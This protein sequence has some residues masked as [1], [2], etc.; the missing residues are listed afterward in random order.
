M[1]PGDRRFSAVHRG[2]TYLFRGPDEQQRFISDPDRYAT[3]RFGPIMERVVNAMSAGKGGGG[4]DLAGGKVVDMPNEYE[5]WLEAQRSD[6][7]S[8]HRV[9]L[10][11][12]SVKAP[13]LAISIA[14][15]GLKIV[16]V[17]ESW[18]SD[19]WN[20]VTLTDLQ[21]ALAA[22][23]GKFSIA[24]LQPTVRPFGIPLAELVKAPSGLRYVVTRARGETFVFQTRKGDLGLMQ[25]VGFT[26]DPRGIRLRYKLVQRPT[27][28]AAEFK[29]FLGPWKVARIQKGDAAGSSWRGD[30][31]GEI[32]FDHLSRVVFD[33]HYCRFQEMEE[34]ID[35]T[36]EW[37]F[38]PT[39]VP[40]TIGL[41]AQSSPAGPGVLAALGVY[42]LQ[43]DQ[44]K[45]CLAK[46]SP[47]LQSEQ[48]PS[49][50]TIRP[51]SG[52][53]LLTLERYQPSE[54][55]KAFQGRWNVVSQSDSGKAVP[56]KE[57]EQRYFEAFDV[58]AYLR[59]G[60]NNK[61]FPRD[62]A[63]GLF[64][65]DP[66]T[67]PK[68]IT[69]SGFEPDSTGGFKTDE[70]NNYKKQRLVG[71]YKFDGD[72]LTIA[73][74]TN[75]PRPE[76]FESTPGSGVTLLVLERPRQESV[77]NAD[78]VGTQRQPS[79]KGPE[80]NSAKPA[81]FRTVPIT[82]GDIAATITATGTIEPEEVVDVGAQ[83][84]G[85]I[86]K[87][88]D[89]PRGKGK[90]IDYG[91][92]VEKGTILAQI[93]PA[94]Y[95][96]RV[97][98]AQAGFERAKA[99][100]T[101][102]QVKREPDEVAKKAAVAAAEAAVAQSRVALEEAKRDLD[103][104]S[105]KSPCK[106][107]VID[108]R[109]N[110]GQY[111]SPEKSASLF[112]IAK[113]LQKLQIWASVN[114]ADIAKIHKGMAVDFTVDAI[115]KEVFH[116]TVA[117]IRLNAAMTQNV[118]TYTVVVEIKRPT[119]DKASDKG[120]SPIFADAKIGTVPNSKLLPY[121]TANLR[122]QIEQHKDVLLAP[123]A[124]LRWKPRPEQSISA[125]PTK[126]DGRTTNPFVPQLRRNSSPPTLSALYVVEPGGKR[127]RPLGVKTGITDGELTEVS[128]PDVKEGMEVVV[129]E[130]P[131]R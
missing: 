47:V 22:E 127:V 126:Q 51:N 38:N 84:A 100:L 87:F 122:F 20:H 44:L 96:A 82:R 2:R 69:I 58:Y 95:K 16:A 43:G 33:E 72:H 85:Q 83:V 111:A 50:F 25:V 45:I 121:M 5:Q 21:S 37:R 41:H 48:R 49:G 61:L 118:V 129:G 34:G 86:V 40:K 108:R 39:T 78:E 81:T 98:Q 103:N 8:Q 113:D 67:E 52:E 32:N 24:S 97:E 117:D 91:S 102:A 73:Y 17:S 42:E 35:C 55:E 68:T 99:E 18:D 66:T 80:V 10:T 15:Q 3:L 123:N 115:P 6:W 125:V 1:T 56:K 53:I 59:D 63:G 93:D 112:L 89:E 14:P 57:L 19:S 64:V 88:G 79:A 65:L 128:G 7:A 13:H 4:L 94:I 110:V 11:V 60:S 36:L 107:V 30:E 27:S 62:I 130:E 90:A 92:P 105:I 104:T 70:N 120:D 12:T 54:D 28:P 119:S 106:G 31:W 124:A 109:V 46:Y 74:R 9:D 77:A 101:L 131:P 116:G 75:G 23:P 114:E 76:K 71:I 29:A 26:D